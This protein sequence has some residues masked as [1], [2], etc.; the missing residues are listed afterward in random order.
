MLAGIQ[1]LKNFLENED[2][3]IIVIHTVVNF[4]WSCSGQ[5][6]ISTAYIKLPILSRYSAVLPPELI[7]PV[8]HT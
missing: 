4:C 2:M 3:S 6:F 5:Y 7:D 8:F 1:S